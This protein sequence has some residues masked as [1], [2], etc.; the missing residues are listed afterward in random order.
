MLLGGENT[1]ISLKGARVNAGFNQSQVAEALSKSRQTVAAWESGTRVPDAA[2]LKELKR[3]YGMS[4]EDD[5][6]YHSV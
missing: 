2:N 5:F 1:K 6:F 4:E 3:L